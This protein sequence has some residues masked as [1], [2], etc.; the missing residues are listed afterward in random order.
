MSIRCTFQ[1]PTF[2]TAALETSFQDTMNCGEGWNSLEDCSLFLPEDSFGLFGDY[3]LNLDFNDFLEPAFGEANHAFEPLGWDTHEGLDPFQP[4]PHSPLST[5]EEQNDWILSPN[6]SLHEC[7]HTPP[8]S[9]DSVRSSNSEDHASTDGSAAS[10]AESVHQLKA[11]AGKRTF[12]K[13]FSVSSGKDV[14]MHTRKRFSETRKKAVALN[15]MIGVCLHC[16]LRKVA[17]S[18]L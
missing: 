6:I 5:L 13:A 12:F 8:S 1:P 2:R 17:V 4:G 14:R 11:T 3:D 18:W 16:K 15:R 10:G 9:R 7:K